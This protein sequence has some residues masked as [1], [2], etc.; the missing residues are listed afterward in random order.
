MLSLAA[1]LLI[2]DRCFLC[3]L[4]GERVCWACTQSIRVAHR[5]HCPLC[6]LASIFPQPCLCGESDV[7][8]CTLFSLTPPLRK[9]LHLIK[10][11]NQKN[12][13]PL[14]PVL[15]S[16]PQ[17]K[18]LA[19]ISKTKRALLVPIPLHENKEHERGFNQAQ[20]M[21][22]GLSK[23]TGVPLKNLLTR[24]KKTKSQAQIN[25]KNS[26]RENVTKA[27]ECVVGAD[28]D[29]QTQIVLIDDVIT[30]GS[31]IAAAAQALKKKGIVRAWGLGLAQ[32]DWRGRAC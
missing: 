18:S 22:Q 6:G 10:Y 14:I 13:L 26:R 20:L 23:I 9:Y 12:L 29:P 28:V 21:A 17:L 27:F 32:E 16:G 2:P 1:Q 8:F 30:S 5:E 3:G 25:H 19:R 15:L 4:L 11:N 31:T 7:A 24:V